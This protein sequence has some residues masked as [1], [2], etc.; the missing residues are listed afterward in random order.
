[1]WKSSASEGIA[2]AQEAP[3]RYGRTTSCRGRSER[4]ECGIK[5]ANLRGCAGEHARARGERARAAAEAGEGR[6]AR[7]RRA[8]EMGSDLGF[9]QRHPNLMQL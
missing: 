2:R 4:G 1:M 5:D 3:D 9:I 7:M 6:D 8:H